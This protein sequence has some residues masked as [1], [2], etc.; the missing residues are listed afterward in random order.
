MLSG[1]RR[2]VRDGLRCTGVLEGRESNLQAEGGERH[3]KEIERT[4]NP[5]R[6]VDGEIL[7]VV[8]HGTADVVR[9]KLSSAPECR[10]LLSTAVLSPC[11]NELTAR[12]SCFARSSRIDS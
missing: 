1:S 11:D 4:G 9:A 5:C 12:H 6:F 2:N 10:A 8:G 3:H 7:F